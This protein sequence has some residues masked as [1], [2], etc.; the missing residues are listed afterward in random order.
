MNE[1]WTITDEHKQILS[2][3]M[4]DFWKL[5]KASY[6]FPND[7][8]PAHD[9]YWTTLI[10]W[11]DALMKKYNNDPT[12]CRIVMAY[13]DSQSDR[14]ARSPVKQMTVAEYYKTMRLAEE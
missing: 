3:F 1:K 12:V 5:I 9:H 7:M 2:S 6:E 13:I 11:C 8:D 4:A 10:K 14:A